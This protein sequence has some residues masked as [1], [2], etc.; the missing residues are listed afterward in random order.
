MFVD[1]VSSHSSEF[2]ASKHEDCP[3]QEQIT[4]EISKQQG[5]WEFCRFSSGMKNNKIILYV[6]IRQ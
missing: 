5:L 6:L 4:N 2:L 1:S 3:R